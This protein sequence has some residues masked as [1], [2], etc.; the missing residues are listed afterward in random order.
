MC[1]KIDGEYGLGLNCLFFFHGIKFKSRR[2]VSYDGK[3][4][5]LEIIGF[6]SELL[7]GMF[8]VLKG[9]KKIEMKTS[10]RVDMKKTK[11]SHFRDLFLKE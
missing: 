7:K 5:I 8:G 11:N 3:C 1:C 10:W 4:F 2:F 9:K 6:S